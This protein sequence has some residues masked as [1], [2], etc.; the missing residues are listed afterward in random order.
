MEEQH[1]EVEVTASETG[2]HDITYVD[3]TFTLR[4]ACC[5]GTMEAIE[6]VQRHLN[7]AARRI[8]QETPRC[9][10]TEHL[11]IENIRR[12]E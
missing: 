5:F 10:T 3:G 1:V 11:Q 7:E 9:I 2:R 12:A 4:I 8:D 6:K